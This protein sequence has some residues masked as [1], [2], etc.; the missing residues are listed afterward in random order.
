MRALARNVLVLINHPDSDAAP[1]CRDVVEQAGAVDS[2]LAVLE[3]EHRTAAIIAE[4]GEIAVLLEGSRPPDIVFNLVEELGRDPAMAAA[5]PAALARA[6]TAYTG[7]GSEALL[8]TGDKL[9]MRQRLQNCGMPVTEA[10]L[11]GHSL[12]P[13]P[14]GKCA[15]ILKP[16]QGAAS[17]G[18]DRASVVHHGEL[19]PGEAAARR[20]RFGGNWY[21]ERYIDGREFTVSMLDS[22]QGP[23]VLP[24]AEIEFDGYPPDRPR[25]VDYAAKWEADSF[26]ARH[27]V[28]CFPRHT[29]DYGLRD[30]LSR[31][32]LGC[33]ASFGLGGYARVDFRVDCQGRP[34]IID[35]NANP[36]LS[37]DAGFQ[38]ALAEG[39]IT[40]PEAVRLI[41]QAAAP[42]GAS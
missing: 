22:P 21:A 33:W 19:L 42:S 13:A 40:W 31:L 39:G 24:V 15:W 16:V 18:I 11:P 14:R 27:T 38:A 7:S 5:V 20:S 1:D 32:A 8:L 4:P 12:P 25:I 37:P 23:K 3:L 35:V 17:C 2:A 26:E 30:R 6:G 28:R 10:W 36:C 34:W 29:L 41:L 9:A